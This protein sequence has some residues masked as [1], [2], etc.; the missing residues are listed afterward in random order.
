[1]VKKNYEDMLSRFNMVPER[2][3]R[4]DGRTDRQTDL[5]YHIINIFVKLH[6]QSYRG[7]D[8][9]PTGMHRPVCIDLE[10]YVRTLYWTDL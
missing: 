5:L 9:K 10:R 7:A 3:G 6:K 4:T 1:M 2:N 8:K